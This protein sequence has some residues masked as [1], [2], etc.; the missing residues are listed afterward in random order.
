MD[1]IGIA[2]RKMLNDY[3]VGTNL[4]ESV[5]IKKKV[6]ENKQKFY[7]YEVENDK[8]WIYLI[9]GSFEKPKI[10]VEYTIYGYVYEYN[11]R[12]VFQVRKMYMKKNIYC[13]EDLIVYIRNI[14]GVGSKADILYEL[15]NDKLYYMLKYHKEVI[16]AENNGIGKKTLEK[17]TQ[18]L[19]N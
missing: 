16:L 6:Y 2:K 14:S 10:G 13:A 7:I 18:N 4:K 12:K 8:G 3:A 9:Q 5:T 1:V 19:F 15:Y 17:I 11:N